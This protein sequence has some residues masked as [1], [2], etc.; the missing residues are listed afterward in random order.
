ME[1]E[2][3]VGIT[4]R[5]GL[6]EFQ[7]IV[8]SA[9]RA[10][11]QRPERKRGRWSLNDRKAA[12]RWLLEQVAVQQA[13]RPHQDGGP[14]PGDKVWLVE[15]EHKEVPGRLLSAFGTAD[16]AARHAAGMRSKHRGKLAYVE[17]MVLDLPQQ[18]VM[19]AG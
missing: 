16:E 2:N 17:T 12:A 14:A 1:D 9:T 8:V 15:A 18:P 13:R 6:A 19:M 7:D 3:T 10:G 5:L 11:Y 4:V